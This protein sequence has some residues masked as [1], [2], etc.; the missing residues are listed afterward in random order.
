MKAISPGHIVRVVL[1]AATGA[2]GTVQKRSEITGAW[3][4]AIVWP[5]DD[6]PDVY[7]FRDE[8]LEVEDC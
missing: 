1:G 3:K 6:V 2:R 7:T 8:F 4:V 5:G